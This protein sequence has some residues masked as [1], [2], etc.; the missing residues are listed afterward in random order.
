MLENLTTIAMHL[1]TSTAPDM[2]PMDHF[3]IVTMSYLP[4]AFPISLPH[5]LL[6]FSCLLSILSLAEQSCPHLSLLSQSFILFYLPL[7]PSMHSH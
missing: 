5:S 2:L 3:T 7:Q 6:T 1:P 4:V